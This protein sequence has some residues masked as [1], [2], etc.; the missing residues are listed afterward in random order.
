M[1]IGAYVMGATHG[2]IYVRAEYP[3]A[4]H[5]LNRAIEQAREYGTLGENILGR[6]FKFD[7]AVG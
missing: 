6:G 5:R 1:T 3:L 2:I 7:I 4:V